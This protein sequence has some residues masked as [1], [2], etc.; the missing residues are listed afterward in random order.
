MQGIEQTRRLHFAALTP[1]VAVALASTAGV[2]VAAAADLAVPPD[3]IGALPQVAVGVIVCDLTL[4]PQEIDMQAVYQPLAITTQAAITSELPVAA[5]GAVSVAA[6][7]ALTGEI[8]ITPAAG[9]IIQVSVNTAQ[10]TF[11][12]LAC[13]A[14]AALSVAGVVNANPVALAAT[15]QLSVAGVVNDNPVACAAAGQVTVSRQRAAVALVMNFAAAPVVVVIGEGPANSFET[16]WLMTSNGAPSPYQVGESRDT[17]AEAAS[18]PS[19]GSW[20]QAWGLFSAQADSLA[21]LAMVRSLVDFVAYAGSAKRFV[22][23][24][25]KH[26]KAQSYFT[27]VTVKIYGSNEASPSKVRG[28]LTGWTELA[29]ITVATTGGGGIYTPVDSWAFPHVSKFAWYRF[30][31]T[32]EVNAVGNSPVPATI[33]TIYGGQYRPTGN[34]I[35]YGNPHGKWTEKPAL[36]DLTI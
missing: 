17:P 32:S 13:A 10:P 6:T 20:P 3:N 8:A 24:G 34:W 33:G 35:C 22:A 36:A 29:D 28:D 26:Q 14:A 12:S 31:V 9:M 11:D 25:M 30:V 1:V 19:G 4:T 23:L 18:W 7:A 16:D 15:P 21:S 5:A 27:P 2:T